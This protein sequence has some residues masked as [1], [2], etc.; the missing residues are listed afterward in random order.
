M[1]RIRAVAGAFVVVAAVG[2]PTAM[3]VVNT[4]AHQTSTDVLVPRS[5][6]ADK[7]APAT[8][9]LPSHGPAS[10]G[11]QI[12]EALPVPNVTSMPVG[13]TSPYIVYAACA[14][15]GFVLNGRDWSSIQQVVGTPRYWQGTLALVSRDSAKFTGSAGERLTFKVGV[16]SSCP[17]S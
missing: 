4:S 13:G 14:H 16:S 7:K 3:A 6:A 15:P 8:P 17:S 1:R 12:I 11:P 9:E 10:P 2:V 5:V